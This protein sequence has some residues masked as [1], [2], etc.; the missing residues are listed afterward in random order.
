M[1]ISRPQRASP[2]SRDLG[3]D[4]ARG[5]AILLVVAGHVFDGPA[6]DV[7]YA[8]HMPFFFLVGGYL[9][10][11]QGTGDALVRLL[12]K[13]I[14]PYMAFIVLLSLP[15]LI[16]S[17]GRNGVGDLWWRLRVLV[18]GGEKLVAP[19]T[20]FWFPTCY[21]F[22]A[23]AYNA[24]ATRLPAR[25]M[26]AI[27]IACLGLAYVNQLLLPGFWLPWAINV[28]AMAIPLFHI[29]ARYGGVLFHPSRRLLLACCA[30]ALAYTAA[31]AL[32]QAPP[33]AMK[34]ANYGIPIITCLVAV[35]MS[36]ALVGLGRAG[37]QL[38]RASA[39]LAQCSH[40]SMTI[41]YVHM[42]IQMAL[43]GVGLSEPWSR[44]ALTVA[45]S[46]GCHAVFLALP[47]TRRLLLGQGRP[48]DRRQGATAP[49]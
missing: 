33:M 34:G 14:V 2:L 32:F 10:K 35:A 46:L 13:L 17:A 22:T 20:I 37:A 26:W 47:A 5:I 8:F 42:P 45:A 18:L 31:I 44:W 40:A 19:L 49:Q 30:V 6:K 4:V 38:P 7:I 43:A 1:E 36:S 23:L 41:M 24:L 39:I 9:F 3:L 27:S 12:R 48:N 21:F 16:E 28:C 11:A 29:G 25:G 15:G